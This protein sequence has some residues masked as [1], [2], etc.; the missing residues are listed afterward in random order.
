M[1]GV[2]TPGRGDRGFC[3]PGPFAVGPASRRVGRRCPGDGFPIRV[4]L[5]WRASL[6]CLCSRRRRLDSADRLAGGDDGCLRSLRVG[7]SSLATDSLVPHHCR[8]LGP[9]RTDPGNV[10][11]WW[12]PLGIGRGGRR[13]GARG[14]RLGAVGRPQWLDGPGRLD[15][16]RNRVGGRKPRC[17]AAHCRSSCRRG[18]IDDRRHPVRP[19]RRRRANSGCHCSRGLTVPSHSLPERED[20]DLQIAPR[21]DA[22]NPR[23]QR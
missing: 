23:R 12:F 8:R 4:C 18:D 7:L 1:D 22:N 5:L 14:H 13:R 2:P 16:G 9:V 11:V 17:L 6:F 19:V 20:A 3:G 21:A 10:S 15:F